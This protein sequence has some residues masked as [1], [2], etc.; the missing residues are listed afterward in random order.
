MSDYIIRSAAPDDAAALSEIYSYY[1]L[2]TAVSFEYSAPDS[3]EF[4]KRITD[5][6]K[7]YPYLVLE[8]EGEIKGYAYAAPFKTRPAYKYSVETT[9]YLKNG[10]QKSGYGR[11]LVSAL[12]NEL[13][14]RGFTNANACIAYT[15]TEDEY[16]THNS[17]DFHSHIGYRLVGIFHKCAYKFDRW[18]D[19]LWMEKH[20]GEHTHKA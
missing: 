13:R 16:L 7:G 18:Y 10:C 6:L 9:V 19:M 2:N 14:L 8:A 11:A 15:E 17:M 4:R 12:E 3:E 1:V 20:I 5:T